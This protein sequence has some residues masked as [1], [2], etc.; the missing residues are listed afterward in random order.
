MCA[1]AHSDLALLLPVFVLAQTTNQ[2]ITSYRL[3]VATPKQVH[4]LGVKS[5]QAAAHPSELR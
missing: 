5:R 1:V 2:R 4:E 3:L